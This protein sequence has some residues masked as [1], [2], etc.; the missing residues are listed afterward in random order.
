MTSKSG[1]LVLLMILL[2]VSGLSFIVYLWLQGIYIP[3]ESSAEAY[4]IK[5]VDVSS[6]QGDIDWPNLQNDLQ[7]TY[8]KAT[9]GSGFVDPYFKENWKEAN[10][11]KLRV[12][13]YHFFSFDSEGATQAENFIKAVPVSNSTLPPVIDVEFYGDKEKDPPDSSKV[14]KELQAMR[15]ELEEHYGKDVIL[16]TTAEAYERYIQN[17]FES[18]E[19]WI[20]DVVS[21]PNLPDG[22][23]W[24][25]WQYTD[26]E[27]LEGYDGEEQFIDVNVFRG[28]EREFAQYGK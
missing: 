18:C 3:N 12:G 9:E 24:T 20:R 4:P 25:F 7:F 21:K 2:I 26:R 15:S 23:E 27:T 1:K 6:Y 22:R 10:H 8:I 5:G 19:I 11:T 16:Y 14:K 13:A 28:T 17:D